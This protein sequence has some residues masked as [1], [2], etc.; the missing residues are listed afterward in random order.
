MTQEEK[1]LLLKDLCARL[2]YDVKVKYFDME[3]PYGS[4]PVILTPHLLCNRWENI[5]DVKPYLRPMPSM[6]QEERREYCNE[7]NK[8]LLMRYRAENHYPVID[9]LLSHHFD[10]RGLIPM[11]LALEA[12]KGMY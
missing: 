10:F 3:Y 2:P 4:E 8:V 12:P 7:C 1:Q 5:H 9:W 6:T 11:G